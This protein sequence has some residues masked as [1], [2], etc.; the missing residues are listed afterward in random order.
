VKKLSTLNVQHEAEK[1]SLKD[2]I[3][4]LIAEWLKLHDDNQHL[5]EKL[6]DLFVAKEVDNETIH[7]L[8]KEIS[9]LKLNVYEA[10]GFVIDQHKLG[11]NK[12]L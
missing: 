5:K 2:E 8:Q 3:A 12:A 11:F 9:Q 1:E 10:E 6:S 4:Y 7:L